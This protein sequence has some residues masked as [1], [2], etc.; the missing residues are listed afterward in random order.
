MKI[1]GLKISRL[2]A[3]GLLL[4]AIAN[5]PYGYYRFLRIAIT[6]IAGINAYREYEND[7]TVLLII[8]V[9]VA[10][11]FNPFI[12]IYLDKA[13]WTPIDVITGLLFGV[14]AFISTKD[15]NQNKA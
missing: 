3:C 5:L 8:F 11:L 1:D 14:T 7:N 4:I 10:I 15:K 13:T 6:I 2:I 9:A 12:P